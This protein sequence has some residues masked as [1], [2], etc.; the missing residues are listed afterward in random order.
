MNTYRL[1][2]VEHYDPA[3][4]TVGVGAGIRVQELNKL[5]GADRLMF[6]A[7]P[8]YPESATVGGVLA[9]ERQGP[10]R[11]GYGGVRDFCIGIRFVTGDGRIA[12][13]GGHVVK[14]VAGYDLMK[15]LIG[16]RGTLAVITSASFKLF[17]APR[18][19]RTFV[20]EFA[21]AEEALHFRD[22]IIR[23]P[24]SPMC[25]DIVSPLARKLMFREDFSDSWVISV[26]AAGSDAVLARYRKELGSAITHELEGATETE[27]WRLIEDFSS[28]KTV[29]PDYLS[30][31]VATVNLPISRV[32]AFISKTEAWLAR[33]NFDFALVGRAGTG[34]MILRICDRVDED[35][36]HP[37]RLDEP[38][39]QLAVECE[40][41]AS[42]YG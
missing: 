39:H 15:L 1:S 19:T 26:R 22:L 21:T 27:M 7:D 25:L 13:G 8:A 3:D 17:P 35:V 42:F 24:L 4:L 9:A 31:V 11:Q 5:V 6:A 28:T 30:A 16:S 29:W 23:S 12:K 18:Q 34:G 2:H 20:A 38:W 36:I 33:E 14:N 32:G 41:G 10:L 37:D 40:A